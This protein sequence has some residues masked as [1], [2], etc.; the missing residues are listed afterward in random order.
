VVLWSDHGWHLGEKLH[1]RK[2]TLWEESTRSVLMAAVPGLT[3]PGGRCTSPVSYTDIYPTVA[4]L[5][6]TPPPNRIEGLS[7]RG[8]LENPRAASARPAVTTYLR[9]NHAVRDARWRYIRYSDG[10]EELY[11][12]ETDP[13]EWRNV[14]AVP[15]NAAVKAA[16]ARW[17]PGTD[18][19]DAPTARAGA[20]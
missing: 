10:G 19:E 5:C 8:R 20:E 9:G 16:L 6:G 3:K 13:L 14:A 2:F 1:W 17:L 11:D 18:A 12:H 7:F 4:E 15:E